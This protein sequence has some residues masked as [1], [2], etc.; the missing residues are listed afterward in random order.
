MAGNG[1]IRATDGNASDPAYGIVPAEFSGLWSDQ[2]FRKN[3][4]WQFLKNGIR[5]FFKRVFP[6]L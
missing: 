3:F 6:A 5:I 1:T 4:V 2:I